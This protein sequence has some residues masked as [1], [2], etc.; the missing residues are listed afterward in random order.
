MEEIMKKKLTQRVLIGITAL[1]TLT[2]IGAVAYAD[3]ALKQIT[4]YQNANLKVLVDGKQI[5][6][7][8]EDGI[9]YPLVYNGHSYVSAKAI[10]EALGA[11]VQWDESSETVIVASGNSMPP[12]N[13]GKADNAPVPVIAPV[14]A[15]IPIPVPLNP[16]VNTAPPVNTPPPVN[17]APPVNAPPAINNPA[18]ATGNLKTEYPAET[19]INVI[20]ADGYAI[21]DAVLL[22]VANGLRTG[23]TSVL[24]IALNHVKDAFEGENKAG[25]S[26]TKFRLAISDMRYKY[27]TTQLNQLADG[28]A[29]AVNAKKYEVEHTQATMEIVDAKDALLDYSVSVPVKKDNLTISLSFHIR[30]VFTPSIHPNG[31]S[32]M[33]LNN[34]I[35]L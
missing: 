4:A 22:G 21:A 27:T 1:S 15:P 14:P 33:L 6:Q 25:K 8:S 26:L 9:M 34:I 7:S 32:I 3:L 5:D 19:S 2:A 18:P 28:I 17:T 20:F 35:L 11:T 24:E 30:L 29:A 13:A 16:P 23:N 31:S 12:G 10:A